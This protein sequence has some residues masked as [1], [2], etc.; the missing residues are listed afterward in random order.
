MLA[1]VAEARED[2]DDGDEETPP[3]ARTEALNGQAF[4]LLKQAQGHTE[5]AFK[6]VLEP[7]RDL[8]KARE[9]DVEALR[10]RVKD[11]EAQLGAAFELR[12]KMLSEQHIRDMLTSDAQRANERKDR[13]LK[14]VESHAPKLLAA[15]NPAATA[16][17]DLMRS[18]N[19]EQ[20]GILLETDFLT[21]EQKRQVVTVL[22]ASPPAPVPTAEPEQ[23][24][25]PVAS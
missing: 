7:M 11:L 21:P 15:M 13:A 1:L 5:A 8:L 20:R 12:E 22:E 3:Q 4:V 25:E 2:S 24:S 23:K 19:P 14:L 16:V 6:L 18:M 17:V 10:A 9:Q